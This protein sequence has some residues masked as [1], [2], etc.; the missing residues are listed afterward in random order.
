MHKINAQSVDQVGLVLNSNHMPFM[1]FMT[2][3]PKVSY[4]EM[5]AGCTVE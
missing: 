4:R 3:V 1:D 2:A 5:Y